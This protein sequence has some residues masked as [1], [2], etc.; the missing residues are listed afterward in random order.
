M[1]D[2][3]PNC[4]S[5]VYFSEL[6]SPNEDV[7]DGRSVTRQGEARSAQVSATDSDRERRDAGDHERQCRRR[8]A[9]GGQRRSDVVL[10]KRGGPL[11][12]RS[13]RGAT[14]PACESLHWR[15]AEDRRGSLLARAG[16]PHQLAE[17]STQLA[18][19][20]S[21]KAMPRP[22]RETTS[23][24]P[25]TEL[26]RNNRLLLPASSRALTDLPSGRATFVPAVT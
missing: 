1:Q 7:A 9:A 16:T 3:I 26:R 25:V 8:S 10:R 23:T 2:Q 12:G 4:A 20:S 5:K 18:C 15:G 22:S 14:S 21:F 24:V 19:R 13:A 6:M 11:S 17:L